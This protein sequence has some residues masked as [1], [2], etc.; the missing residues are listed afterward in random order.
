MSAAAIE[1]AESNALADAHAALY[2]GRPSALRGEY[3][4][5]YM[6]ALRALVEYR[7]SVERCRTSRAA[8]QPSDVARADGGGG[9]NGGAT[10]PEG[11]RP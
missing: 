10:A 3:A 8:A 2:Q 1:Q 11:E 5:G 7:R 6:D 9:S 4:Q